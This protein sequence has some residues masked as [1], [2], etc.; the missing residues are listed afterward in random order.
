MKKRIRTIDI[1]DSLSEPFHKKQ[2]SVTQ[3][4]KLNYFNFILRL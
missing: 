3:E 4:A 1:L 2:E